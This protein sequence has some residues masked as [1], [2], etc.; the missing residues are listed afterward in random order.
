MYR[1]GNGRSPHSINCKIQNMAK[2]VEKGR[3]AETGKF[4]SIEYAQ[5]HPST[6]VVEKVKVGP[7]KRRK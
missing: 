1:S 7:T 2:T 3:S 5:K 4:V 6:T